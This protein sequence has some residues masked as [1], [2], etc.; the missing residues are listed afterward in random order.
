MLPEAWS[1]EHNE[2]HHYRL[3]EEAD[4]DLV[5]RNLAFVRAMKAPKVGWWVGGWVGE[6]VGSVGSLVGG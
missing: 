4:P 3:G 2:L 5:Q 1:V 6:W